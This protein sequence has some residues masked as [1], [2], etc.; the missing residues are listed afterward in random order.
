MKLQY[1]NL[2]RIPEQIHEQKPAVTSNIHRNTGFNKPEKI[3]SLNDEMSCLW[4]RSL[5]I[6]ER[7]FTWLISTL[8]QAYLDKNICSNISHMDDLLVP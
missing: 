1:K 8:G 6:F 2:Y 3:K 4:Q 7:K 5:I